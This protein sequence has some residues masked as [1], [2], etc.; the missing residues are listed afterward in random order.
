MIIIDFHKK[1]CNNDLDTMAVFQDFKNRFDNNEDIYVRFKP[2][3]SDGRVGLIGKLSR[4]SNFDNFLEYPDISR[5]KFAIN[6][7]ASGVRISRALYNTK[8]LVLEFDDRKNT[9]KI[10]N[11]MEIEYLQGYTGPTVWKDKKPS[12][13]KDPVSI[14]DRLGNSVKKDDFVFYK[15]KS[16]FGFGKIL[17]ITPGG[18][19]S[20][21]DLENNNRILLGYPE[22]SIAVANE[23]KNKMITAKLKK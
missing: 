8:D 6:A 15:S 3:R 21:L 12:V 1:Y 7:I 23:M 19:V 10:K 16:Y 13:K 9:L 20:V 18:K 17:S 14:V 2:N 22:K 5:H 4:I 11:L